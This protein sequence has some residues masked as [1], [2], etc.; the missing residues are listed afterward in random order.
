VNL[1]RPRWTRWRAGLRLAANLGGS[2]L[3]CLL[4]A[5]DLVAT[6]SVAEAAPERTQAVA[7]AINLWMWRAVPWVAAVGLVVLAFDVRRIRRVPA[8]DRRP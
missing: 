6:I 2:A 8:P 1:F 4:C 5:S 3:F 7:H